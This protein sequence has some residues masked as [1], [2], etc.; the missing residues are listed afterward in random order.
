[1]REITFVRKWTQS[2][3]LFHFLLFPIKTPIDV[4]S[5]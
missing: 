4:V 2:C 5:D 1:M 3:D